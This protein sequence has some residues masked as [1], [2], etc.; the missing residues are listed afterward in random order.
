MLLIDCVWSGE[1]CTT[2]DTTMRKWG[3]A[4]PCIGEQDGDSTYAYQR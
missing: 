3:G 1:L 2:D 4:E